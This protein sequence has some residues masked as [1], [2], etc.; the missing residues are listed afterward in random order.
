MGFIQLLVIVIAMF[1]TSRYVSS[2]Y[3]DRAM[4]DLHQ[5]HQYARIHEVFLH[6]G[7]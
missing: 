2:L 1:H 6:W 7:S 3:T 5:H 4:I